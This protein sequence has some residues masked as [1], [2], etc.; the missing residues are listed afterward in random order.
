MLLLLLLFMFLLLL[1]RSFRSCR[2]GAII[3]FF[4]S[5]QICKVISDLWPGCKM[6]TGSARHSES[7]GGVERFNKTIQD[8]VKAM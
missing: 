7:N 1:L 4:I 2:D 8:K 5:M 6:I 3:Q